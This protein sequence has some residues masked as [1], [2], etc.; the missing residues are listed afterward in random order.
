MNNN[1]SWH[2]HFA[3]DDKTQVSIEPF[4]DADLDTIYQIELQAHP[5]PWQRVHFTDSLKASHHHCLGV[6]LGSQWLAYAIVSCAGGE[7]ELLL[8]VVDAP[9]QKR[10]IAK[11]LMTSI[12]QSLR[13]RAD[14]LFLE[15]RAS[16][17]RAIRLYESLEFNQVG[18]RPGYYPAPG[19]VEDALIYA[20]M[21]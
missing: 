13:G 9:W 20:R 8:L 2:S 10:G 14:T 6:R 3:L 19:G 7:A 15:V 12:F 11:G 18:T 16:N 17:D 4:I 1:W 5:T 21:L